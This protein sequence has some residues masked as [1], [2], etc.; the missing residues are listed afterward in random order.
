MLVVPF[1]SQIGCHV[2]ESFWYSYCITSVGL[3]TTWSQ[4]KNPHSIHLLESLS[5]LCCQRRVEPSTG[6]LQNFSAVSVDLCTV[7]WKHWLVCVVLGS[8]GYQLQ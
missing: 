8:E 2:Y 6:L 4:V 1:V 5:C 3:W 7:V